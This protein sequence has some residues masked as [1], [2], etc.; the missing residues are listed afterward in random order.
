MKSN[1]ENDHKYLNELNH[2]LN[3]AKGTEE[4]SFTLKTL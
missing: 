4:N 2:L 1:K 3:E